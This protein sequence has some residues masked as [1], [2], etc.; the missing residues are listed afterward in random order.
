MKKILTFSLI[1]LSFLFSQQFHIAKAENNPIYYAKITST[2]IYLCSNPDENS[3]IFEI[4][5]SYFVKVEYSVDDYY[6]VSYLD[7]D[8]YVKKDKV[9]L[10]NGTPKIPYFNGTFEIFVPY[11]LYQ[12]PSQNSAEIFRLTSTD[13]K[14][15]YYGK[16]NGEQVMSDNNVWYYCCA[17]ANGEKHYGY[18]FSGVT[19]LLTEPVI[20]TETFDIVSEEILTSPTSLSTGTKIML[21]ISISVPSA[22]ILYFLIKPSKIMQITKSK[23]QKKKENKKIHHGDYFEFDERDL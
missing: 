1:I 18:I 14:I 22:L 19:D 17:T 21:I 13:I 12:S 4:P 23:K 10:M 11:S 6:K 3:A 16:I 20:N 15:E 5:Y 2:G 9:S 7:I 8:G